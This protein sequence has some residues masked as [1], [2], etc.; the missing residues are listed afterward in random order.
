MLDNINTP[1]VMRSLKELV[2][3]TNVYLS[4]TKRVDARL[5][6]VDSAA[7]FVTATLACLGVAE[8]TS[9]IGLGEIG[10]DK[11]TSD[12][13]GNA[14]SEDAVAPALDVVVKFRDEIRTLAKSGADPDAIMRAC[15]RLRDVGLPSLGVKLD[16]REGG[17]LWKMSSP[18]E[19][20][21][22]QEREAEARAKKDAE[23]R[24]KK[25]E[26]S[27]KNAEKEAAARVDPKIMFTL[28]EYEGLYAEYDEDG[29]PTKTKD[30]EEI[31]KAQRKKLAKASFAQKTAHEKYLAKRTA[32]GLA[33]VKL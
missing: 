25:E 21:K 27:R 20:L 16:D 14:K 11:D 3:A 2:G 9:G 13:S 15:D 18:E 29:V 4:R 24:R 30:G 32:E 22:E 31:A 8:T 10:A 5:L 12:S 23:T 28:G 19:L 1:G 7:R 33:E 17:A 6:L 26:A